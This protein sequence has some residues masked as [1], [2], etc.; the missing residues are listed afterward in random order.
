[1]TL[2]ELGALG[3]FIGSFLVLITLVILVIQVRETHK[4]ILA[5]SY[6][7]S[8]RMVYEGFG[9]GFRASI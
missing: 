5:N 9:H 3:E 7:E 6:I 4:A 1:M 8:A 2:A